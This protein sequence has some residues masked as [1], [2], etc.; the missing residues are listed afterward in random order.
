MSFGAKGGSLSYEFPAVGRACS[1][2]GGASLNKN[3]YEP[4]TRIPQPVGFADGETVIGSIARSLRMSYL[5]MTLTPS[6]R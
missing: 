2:N 1:S 6:Q 4:D 3:A 5:E